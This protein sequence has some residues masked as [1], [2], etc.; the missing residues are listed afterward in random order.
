[1]DGRAGQQLNAAVAIILDDH[2]RKLVEIRRARGLDPRIV[3]YIDHLRGRAG[4]M[5]GNPEILSVRWVH[6]DWPPVPLTARD[7]GDTSVFVGARPARYA[8]SHDLTISGWHVGPLTH[9][10][11]DPGEIF[12]I[13]EWEERAGNQSPSEQTAQV[14][15]ERP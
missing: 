3:L 12:A 8:L 11:V 1:M 10:T 14:A 2:A 5:A 7:V 6:G 4:A 9:L 13:Q 15:G